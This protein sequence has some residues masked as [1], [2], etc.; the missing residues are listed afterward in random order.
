MTK[1]R[2]CSQLHWLN[3]FTHRTENAVTRRDA[4]VDR[5]IC[6]FTWRQNYWRENSASQEFSLKYILIGNLLWL[7]LLLL[8]YFRRSNGR[9]SLRGVDCSHSTIPLNNWSGMRTIEIQQLRT[10][11]ANWKTSM[12][13]GMTSTAWF[14]KGRKW[15]VKNAHARIV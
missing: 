7:L 10:S 11:G 6:R 1:A 14:R 13:A 9:C 8:L 2:T 5:R 4:R 15:S 3:V 12:N